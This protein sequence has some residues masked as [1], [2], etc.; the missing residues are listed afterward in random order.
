VKQHSA[1][2]EVSGSVSSVQGYTTSSGAAY[3]VGT[4]DASSN[5][6]RLQLPAGLLDIGSSSKSVSFRFKL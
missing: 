4:N 3:I 5:T 2:V 6:A 1:I